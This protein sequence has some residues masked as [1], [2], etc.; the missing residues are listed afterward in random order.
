[1]SFPYTAATLTTTTRQ[2][3]QHSPTLRQAMPNKLV[4]SAVAI[5]E[6]NA[7]SREN[8]K[9]NF[10]TVSPQPNQQQ[11]S[12]AAAAFHSNR[13]HP[14]SFLHQQSMPN[15]FDASWNS[16]S[17]S[18]NNSLEQQ[19]LQQQTRRLQ[20]AA[21][22]PKMKR[23]ITSAD[24]KTEE[25]VA[26]STA[27]ETAIVCNPPPAEKIK[28]RKR[29]VSRVIKRVKPK[30][31]GGET[32]DER[33]K[34][35]RA[36]SGARQHAQNSTQD[37]GT[38][39]RSAAKRG[40]SQPPGAAPSRAPVDQKQSPDLASTSAHRRRVIPLQSGTSTSTTSTSLATAATDKNRRSKSQPRL[41]LPSSQGSTSSWSDAVPAKTSLVRGTNYVPTLQTRHNDATGVIQRSS[42]PKPQP[43][44]AGRTEMQKSKSARQIDATSDRNQS[45]VHP[46]RE[47][48]KQAELRKAKSARQIHDATLSE[49]ATLEQSRQ[50]AKDIASIQAELARL[51][52]AQATKNKPA[53]EATSSN[54]DRVGRFERKPPPRTRSSSEPQKLRGSQNET[55][56]GILVRRRTVGRVPRR[57]SNPDG[58]AKSAAT[59]DDTPSPSPRPVGRV[60][61]R[62][63]T[64]SAAVASPPLYASENVSAKDL[65]A[66]V[67]NIFVKTTPT[68]NIKLT[69]KQFG[70]NSNTQIGNGESNGHV[71]QQIDPSEHK[72]SANQAKKQALVVSTASDDVD[73]KQIQRRNIGRVPRPSSTTPQ[74]TD[75]DPIDA[76]N[77][78]VADSNNNQPPSLFNNARA[79]QNELRPRESQC[80]NSQRKLDGNLTM[81]SPAAATS[82]I[83]IVQPAS[84]PDPSAAAVPATRTVPTKR[85]QRR[86]FPVNN[87]MTPVNPEVKR[88]VA[89]S[90]IAG[91]LAGLALDDSP[92]QS[93][94]TLSLQERIK[95]FQS[96]SG[97]K[98]E[99]LHV[100]NIHQV[101]RPVMSF[102]Q[103]RK[104]GAIKIQAV[105]R[106]MIQRNSFRRAR[107]VL[108]LQSFAR[109][110]APRQ[111]FRLR[112]L[113][114]EYATALKRQKG[115]LEQVHRRKKQAIDSINNKRNGSLDKL[116][117][118]IESDGAEEFVRQ[119]F[120]ENSKLQLS[121]AKL[122]EMRATIRS[123]HQMNDMTH[124]S[125]LQSVRTLQ[126][127][128]GA[129]TEK[130][131]VL[132]RKTD[133]YEERIE[134]RS[135]ELDELR[136]RIAYESSLRKLMDKTLAGLVELIESRCGDE[137]LV[138]KV[139]A[140]SA[141][142]EYESDHESYVL[143]DDEDSLD[144]GQL[145][146]PVKS[147]KMST[148]DGFEL[149]FKVT[150]LDDDDDISELCNSDHHM[151]GI[152]EEGE[153]EVEYDEITVDSEE[154]EGQDDDTLDSDD[155][156]SVWDGRHEIII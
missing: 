84:A 104:K 70:K 109:M 77:C 144:A 27:M 117:S 53:V 16:S 69:A 105:T 95:L 3:Q 65:A 71:Q 93:N 108:C 96:A 58:G 8:T 26:A 29:V 1:M 142:E 6:S 103:K 21:S 129:L 9:R 20:L 134:T 36:N 139:I 66:A 91:R 106:G 28:R 120:Q 118:T 47:R 112:M 61:R 39:G 99:L 4:H 152:A 155:A 5:F 33:G 79:L 128:V 136:A 138:K 35:K 143:D 13:L 14:P 97:V 83:A 24:I 156:S 153:Y 140:I 85:I 75:Q 23:R 146:T 115:D 100:P 151:L 110:V 41:A 81:A 92:S 114:R 86:V 50:L 113:H 145:Q 68:S 107:A 148:T 119:L 40:K 25:S 51:T 64:M 132:L 90:I 34:M 135:A 18:S 124:S 7:N 125:Q 80:K 149:S 19:Q 12:A 2:Q 59:S 38:P 141:D 48:P 122:K 89:G 60:P 57:Q 133:K 94:N 37:A 130:N 72:A 88:K 76:N 111:A 102:A 44:P 150:G 73:E 42:S 22:A 56:P 30:D 49:T 54:R 74:A 87:S 55:S 52:E 63:T 131:D 82:S 43:R 78:N 123:M 126:D 154:F 31:V 45:S 46:K 11:R 15:T 127:A 32:A 10:K 62:R 147:K 101:G 116:E 98:N 67:D 17:S 137:G 121:N